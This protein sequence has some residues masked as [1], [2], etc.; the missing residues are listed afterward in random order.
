MVSRYAT[1]AAKALTERAFAAILMIVLAPVFVACALAILACDGPPVLFIDTRVGRQGK[2]FGLAKFRSMRL[3]P[4]PRITSGGDPRITPLGARLRR[5]KLDELP[6]LWNVV[7]GQMSLIGPRP[8]TPSLVDFN[9][10]EWA[11]ILE[12]P[13]GITGAASV[14]YFNEAERLRGAADPAAKYREQILPAK[15]AIERAYLRTC[16]PLGDLRLLTRT[17]S[18][19]FHA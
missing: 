17:L 5:W 6:Q 18:R 9:S 4:G 8:E 2:L 12:V 10:L 14:E 3:A 1:G 15:L 11:E 13:P 19:L 16:S 7:R